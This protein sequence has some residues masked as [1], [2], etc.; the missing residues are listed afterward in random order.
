VAVLAA[1]DRGL[2]EPGAGLTVLFVDLDDF[3]TV[4][5]GYGHA[6]GDELLRHVAARLVKAVRPDDLCARLGGD[7]FAV[8]LQDT[9]DGAADVIA[10]RLVRVLG[11]PVTLMGRLAQV[12]ASIGLARFSKDTAAEQLVQRADIAMYAA[13][14]KGK[15]RVQAF[16]PSLLQAGCYLPANSSRRPRPPVRSSTSAPS[17]CAARVRTQRIGLRATGPGRQCMS[18][19]RP[20]S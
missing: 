9:T 12:G 4:N 10:Q 18:T 3:K 6:A 14:A 1:L 5:D 13:K 19:S 17:C 11:S 20:H 15:N 7:E 16:D 2:K 8:L